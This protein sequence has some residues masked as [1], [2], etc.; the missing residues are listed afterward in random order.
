M[1]RKGRRWIDGRKCWRVGT[2]NEKPEIEVYTGRDWMS[3][4]KRVLIFGSHGN[5]VEPLAGSHCDRA[6]F[7]QD[8][9]L[10]KAARRAVRRV[11]PVL[12][13]Q[14]KPLKLVQLFTC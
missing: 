5:L 7:T 12:E 1:Q 8:L 3:K 10:S 9:V 11:L 6:I 4:H 2:D 14:V 13:M